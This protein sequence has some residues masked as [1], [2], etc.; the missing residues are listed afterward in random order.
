MLRAFWTNFG[1]WPKNR[2]K[3]IKTKEFLGSLDSTTTTKCKAES[4][5]HQVHG[6]MSSF[7][8]AVRHLSGVQVR[9]VSRMVLPPLPPGDLRRL[10]VPGS[11]DGPSGKAGA[12]GG[13]GRRGAGS[14]GLTEGGFCCL[15]RRWRFGQH[16]LQVLLK[17]SRENVP[18]LNIKK[19]AFFFQYA[20][21]P[22]FLIIY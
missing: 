14:E 16:V 19:V 22:G 18:T 2:V 12:P 10:V 13:R 5:L 6:D 8:N 4:W 17:L 9:V 1:D 11:E 21:C 20:S 7:A 3:R 15:R